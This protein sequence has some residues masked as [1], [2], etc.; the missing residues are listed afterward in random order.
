MKFLYKKWEFTLGFQSTN[1]EEVQEL[2]QHRI[3]IPF[4]DLQH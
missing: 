2:R 4:L 1:H 3:T